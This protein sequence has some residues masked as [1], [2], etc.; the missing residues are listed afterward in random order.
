MTW[1]TH[2]D[3]LT[4][5]M[6]GIGYA[7]MLN[8]SIY[9][10]ISD[11][12]K[13]VKGHIDSIQGRVL[14]EKGRTGGNVYPR[15][16]HFYSEK[17]GM[18]AFGSRVMRTED[19]GEN[20]VYTD[21]EPYDST[22]NMAIYG[23]AYPA[24]QYIVAITEN[25]WITFGEY[26]RVFITE[27]KGGLM[28]GLTEAK[29]NEMFTIYPNPARERISISLSPISSILSFQILTPDGRLVLQG[30]L[31]GEEAGVNISGLSSGLYFMLVQDDRQRVVRKFVKE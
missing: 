29:G 3:N 13:L 18:I 6:F 21:M 11:R 10:G 7:C 19:G 31:N 8:D 5:Q 20:W 4:Y 15:N 16:I 26:G 28:T 24:L 23:Y 27:N 30:R 25:K 17:L 2:C 14:L 22:A 1:K 12:Y 9:I